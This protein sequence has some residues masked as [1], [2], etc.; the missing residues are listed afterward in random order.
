L[1]K[2]T[3]SELASYQLFTKFSYILCC[4]IVKDAVEGDDEFEDFQKS[5]DPYV[6]IFLNWIRLQ[7]AHL[8]A[9]ESILDFNQGQQRVEIFLAALR[10]SHPKPRD[11]SLT[12]PWRTTMKVALASGSLHLLKYTN[13]VMNT[14]QP[15]QAHDQIT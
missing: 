2:D 4:E 9:L 8:A 10:H 12:E 15:Y 5:K 13:L 11:H 6:M 3:K 14:I 1:P 7:V